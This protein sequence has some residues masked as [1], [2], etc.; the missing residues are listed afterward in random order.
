MKINFA[1][2]SDYA[3]ISREGKL[4]VMGIFDRLTYAQVPAV[5]PVMYLAFE[6]ELSRDE[7]GQPFTLRID[8]VDQDG[9]LVNQVVAQGGINLKP[10]KTIDITDVPH[11]PQVISFG[12]VT[13]Q[14][15]GGY[16]V[17][18]WLTDRLDYT[19]RFA[20]VDA[21]GD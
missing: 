8:L 4:S 10:G 15:H 13:F 17:N 11:I 12:S 20:V 9:K 1:H 16:N 14:Q 2:L 3:S 21:P 7:L 6:V 18:F 5:H 19:V